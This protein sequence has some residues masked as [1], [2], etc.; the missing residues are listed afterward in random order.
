REME[1]DP[2]TSYQ[3]EVSMKDVLIPGSPSAIAICHYIDHWLVSSAKLMGQEMTDLVDVVNALP[4][5]FV[6]APPS[7]YDP[8]LCSAP[9][10]AGGELGSGVILWVSEAGSAPLPLRARGRVW[11]P[12]GI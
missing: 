8:S 12:P 2:P 10:S 3:P 11:G 6:H 4:E 7:T 9:S 5:D 1:L